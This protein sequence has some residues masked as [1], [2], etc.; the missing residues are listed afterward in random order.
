MRR[1]S[2]TQVKDR[3]GF[4]F[5]G[6]ED[7]V[8]SQADIDRENQ[9][10]ALMESF[11]DRMRTMVFSSAPWIGVEKRGFEFGYAVNY[12]SIRVVSDEWHCGWPF[13][14]AKWVEI[15]DGAVR[16]LT[17]RDPPT[18]K[19]GLTAPRFLRSEQ[20][21]NR[22]LPVAPIWSGLVTNTFLYAT[23]IWALM[24]GLKAST[25]AYRT[26]RGRCS[27]CGYEL[28][29]LAKCP[30]CGAESARRDFASPVSLF[31]CLAVSLGRDH[32]LSLLPLRS[33]P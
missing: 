26:H 29:G 24:V 32:A 2:V 1:V 22:H 4:T 16:D 15:G 31:R 14:A 21:W 28:A 18:A 20:M 3:V 13:N 6:H 8:L 7:E 12:L 11:A 5:T 23:L 19:P 27:E 10:L 17:G 25:R 30:E 9:R 33:S